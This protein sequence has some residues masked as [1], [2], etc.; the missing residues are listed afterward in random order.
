MLGA[1]EIPPLTRLSS[2]PAVAAGRLV[3]TAVRLGR[4]RRTLKVPAFLVNWQLGAS[5]RSARK[6]VGKFS[7]AKKR[8]HHFVVRELPIRGEPLSLATIAAEVVLP[9]EKVAQLVDELE[10]DKT[11]L[12]RQNSDRIDWAYPVTVDETPHKVSFST[13]ERIN[14]A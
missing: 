6:K 4:G 13:G 11:F 2:G 14:A 7:T 3:D 1:Q 9:V 5:I 12:F 10:A 8:V